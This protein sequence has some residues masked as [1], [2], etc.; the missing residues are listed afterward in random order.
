MTSKWIT[1][2]PITHRG[3]HSGTAV[4]ENS[5][6]AFKKSIDA[7]LPIECD[8]QFMKDETIVVFHDDTLERL[9][10]IQGKI[11]DLTLSHLENLYL[12][13]TKEQIPT[14]TNL[15]TLVNGRVPILIEIKGR[16][17]SPKK[18][19]ILKNIIKSYSGEIALQSFNPMALTW[20]RKNIPH[21]P[22][23]MIS[24]DWNNSGLKSYQKFLLR[25]MLFYFQVSPS[26]ISI[27]SDYLDSTIINIIRNQFKIPILGWTIKSSD[28]VMQYKELMN[29]FIFENFSPG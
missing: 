16:D 2:R 21:I 19:N 26:F 8:I 17:F 22:R 7:N 10:G 23:G 6:L 18:G 20:C 24:Y 25:Y 14:L 9:T 5:L 3:L 12:Y 28:E 15:F 4:P 27:K 11:S 13:K 1:D 29:N